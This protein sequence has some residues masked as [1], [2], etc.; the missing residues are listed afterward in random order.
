MTAGW[1][2]DAAL[3]LVAVATGVLLGWWVTRPTEPWLEFKSVHATYEPGSSVI[4]VSGEYKATRTCSRAEQ[5]TKPAAPDPLIWRQE[6]LG[7]GP[8]VVVYAPRPDPPELRVGMHGF[9]QQIPLE[10]GILPDGWVVSVTVSCSDEPFAIRSR[11][12]V[13]EFR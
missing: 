1:I 12:T 5:D 6:V 4:H 2:K 7:T 8:Q 3:L 11:S 9:Q 10:T 13:V